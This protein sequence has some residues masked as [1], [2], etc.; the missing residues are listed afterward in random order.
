MQ[1]LERAPINPVAARRA[2]APF[3]ASRTL[4]REAYISEDVLEWERHHFYEQSWVCVGRVQDT[5][6][7][8]TQRAVRVGSE[9]V[10]LV[11]DAS[12]ALRA[13]FNVCR[14]RGHELLEPGAC[15]T[16]GAIR[17]PY[18]AWVYGL[19]GSLKGAPRFNEIPDFDRS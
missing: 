8:G 16:A 13:F 15:N 17:C 7:A 3:G 12:G 5:R 4:P 2:M 6:A 10:L 9:G 19:D 14:H 11:R 1:E 18:H